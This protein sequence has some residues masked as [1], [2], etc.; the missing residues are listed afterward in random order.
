M[1]HNLKT[2]RFWS[3]AIFTFLVALVVSLTISFALP[4]EVLA[5]GNVP[6]NIKPLLADYSQYL[7]TGQSSNAA[8]YSSPM[9]T[10]INDR[11][12]YYNEYFDTGL[13]TKLVSIKSEFQLENSIIT[14]AP[15][16]LHIELLEFVT[17]IGYPNLSTADDYPMIPA[18]RWAISNTE[19]SNVKEALTRYLQSTS[20]E[21][22]P[23]DDERIA[24][25]MATQFD[26]RKKRLAEGETPIGW[27]AG[28]GAPTPLKKLKLEAALVG[29]MTDKS[30]VASGGTVSVSGWSKPAIEPEIAIYLGKDVPA[31]ADPE[32]ARAAISAIGP[33]FEIV[34]LKLPLND[35]ESIL[36]GNIF[37]RYVILGPQDSSRA[38]ADI[39]GLNA[40][41]LR[42]GAEE[43]STT[44]VDALTG[45][46]TAIV[47]RVA[48]TIAGM[49]ETLR[50]GEVIIAGS[51]V[52]PIFLSADDREL[53]YTLEPIGS[54]SVKFGE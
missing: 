33:A 21:I 2:K 10:L 30:K 16:T 35:V 52:A 31:D 6:E 22:T 36:S 14:K 19:N 48:D 18:A 5:V 23:L 28:F 12:N 32:T 29:F 45:P 47:Q 11:R 40:K 38:G 25:G 53:S 39:G 27:K 3:L 13:H 26:L 46:F 20:D 50:A 17:M 37:H 4:Q 15:K 49:G 42:N 24:R 41:I 43:A 44:E 34:D 54:V 9:K 1:E 7:N 8:F 51:L